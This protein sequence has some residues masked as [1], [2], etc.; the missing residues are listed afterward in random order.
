L[1]EVLFS[2]DQAGATFGPVGDKPVGTR[3]RRWRLDCV[4]L[5]MNCPL[6]NVSLKVASHRSVEVNYCPLCGGT[7]LDRLALNNLSPSAAASRR[8]PSRL[9]R[10]AV[11]TALILAGCLIATVAVGAIKLWPAVRSWSE[12]LFSG[13]DTAVTAQARQLAGGLTDQRILEL[14]RSGL[15]RT[16][17]STLKSNSGFEQLL[18]SVAAVPTLGPLVQNGAYLKVFQEAARQRVQN[19]ADLKI[20]GI[21]SPD[22]RAA[23]A[24]VQSALRQAPEGGG[25][26]GTVDPA[27]LELLGSNAFLQLSR[28]GVLERLFGAA[29]RGAQVD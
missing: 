12:S 16:V 17:I 15:D 11:L 2:L 25:I 6:C 29:S 14:S 19:L 10:I 3:Q 8:F 27:V 21:A 24:Q 28:S 23:T 18:N 9:L 4:S 20:D 5:G 13:K 26:A 7:W 1:R 22:I